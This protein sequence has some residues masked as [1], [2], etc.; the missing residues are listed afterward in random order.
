VAYVDFILNLAALLLW[1]NWRAVQFDPLTKRRPATLIGTL[2]PAGTM[3]ARHWQLLAVIGGLLVLRALF[4][5]QIGSAFA[6]VW[7]GKL[8]LGVIILPFRSDLFWRILLFSIFSFA[9]ALGIFYLWLLLLSIL[10]GPEP[11]QRLVRMQLGSIDRWPRTAKIILPFVASALFW[12]LA[13]WLFGWLQISPPMVSVAQRIEQSLII[14]LGN[15]LVWKF[16]IGALFALHLL[17][18]YIYFG[19]HP[20]W[21]YVNT[22]A[23]TL[24][25][26]L[27]K[28]PLRAGKVDFAPVV[29][30]ALVFLLAEF[31]GRGLVLLYGKLPF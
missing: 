19:R 4:Y 12:W 16:L 29:G 11:L 31:A 14:G 9:R 17:N 5:W 21:N 25:T 20:F 28:I 23:Q 26:P 18:S 2:R 13:S 3:R 22:T 1:I 8:D 7:V 10:S 24:L 15:Y 27:G 30:I 6:Q